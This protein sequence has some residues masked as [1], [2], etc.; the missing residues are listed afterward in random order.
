MSVLLSVTEHSLRWSDM[1]AFGHV[2]NGRFL[3]YFEE[4]RLVWLQAL[5]QPWVSDALGPLLA[6]V[7]I[8]FRHPLQWPQ[9]IRIELSTQRIGNSSLTLEHRV[10]AND[11]SDMAYADGTSV[12]VWTDRQTGRPVALPAFIR[13]AAETPLAQ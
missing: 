2:N 11:S 3:T 10:F 13:R 8:N 12:M 4:A 1:D 5:P 6:A 9:A 7:Q